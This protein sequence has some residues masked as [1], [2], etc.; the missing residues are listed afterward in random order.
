MSRRGLGHNG[1]D[2][3]HQHNVIEPLEHR[4]MLAD[5][6]QLDL[7]FDGDGRSPMSFGGGELIGLQPDGKVLL[8]RND[9]GGFRLA[10]LNT[11][12]SVDSTF[13][14]GAALV[15]AA[16]TPFFDVSPVD[17]RIAYV[18]GTSNENQT[19]VGVLKAD[20][21][22]DTSFD[23]DGK[24]VLDLGYA[25]Q[26]V[27]WQEGKLVL[28]GGKSFYDDNY[29]YDY[30]FNA[31]LRRLNANG[32]TDTGF[33]NAGEIDLLGHPDTLDG[34]EAT[35]DG[36]LV[37]AV[38]YQDDNG[39]SYDALRISKYTSDGQ[40]DTSFGAGAGFI[41]AA[42]GNEWY[43]QTNAFTVEP[44][45]TIYHLAQESTGTR[46]RRFNSNGAPSLGP[47]PINLP[48]SDTRQYAGAPRQIA[49]QPDGRMLLFTPVYNLPN[50]ETSWSIT[51]LNAIDGSIDTTYGLN[52][53]AYPKVLDNGRALVQNDGK[54]LISGK[55]FT[56]DGGNFEVLRV[57]SAALDLG[58]V[59]LNT[60]GTLI[61]TGTP[62]GEEIGVRFRTRDSRVVVWIGQNSRAL[63]PSKVKRI[64]LF[65]RGGDDTLII[66]A[67]I[68][69]AYI[70]GEDGNDSLQGGELDDI[71]IG[72]LGADEL[73]GNGGNDR[74]VGE[75]G[76][77]YL[78]GGAGND[79]M[80]GN[81]GNDTL[82]GAGGNDRLFG[83]PDDADTILGGAGTDSAASD[84]EDTYTAVE[85]LLT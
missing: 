77:D 69:G 85:T 82:S 27:A 79:I 39:T 63:A 78:L 68:R 74:M 36:R 41:D 65:G 17:G 25:A 18:T 54:A 34:L 44:D 21:S 49:V 10:R 33:G 9:I 37:V 16:G 32:S 48:N 47:V 72:G 67:G 59:S 14:G 61:V 35:A 28:L 2:R 5:A 24:K 71:M 76:S 58:T 8:R 26:R 62:A 52:G 46:L 23:S 3:K 75:G 12:G 57:D 13:K 81:G 56:A 20:G 11:N 50:Y 64:A 80:L 30:G 38:S 60:K 55:R 1:N 22:A 6:G 45:G 73:Y 66:G 7:T 84:D 31:E 53:A 40:P 19:Q 70:G 15:D 83:G 43:P 42:S 4:R 29:P 51:R